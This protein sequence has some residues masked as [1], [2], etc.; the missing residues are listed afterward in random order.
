VIRDL[1]VGSWPFWYP[2]AAAAGLFVASQ[3]RRL[4]VR[5]L[6]RARRTLSDVEIARAGRPSSPASIDVEPMR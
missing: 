4:G 6:A 2:V 3:L 1:V 5:R